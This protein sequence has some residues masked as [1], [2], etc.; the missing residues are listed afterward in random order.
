MYKS[1]KQIC[2]TLFKNVYVRDHQCLFC[3]TNLVNETSAEI[4]DLKKMKIY[5][6]LRSYVLTN[7]KFNERLGLALIKKNR[8]SVKLF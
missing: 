1:S 3:S 5:E 6:R 4:N 2:N 7:M 8:Y